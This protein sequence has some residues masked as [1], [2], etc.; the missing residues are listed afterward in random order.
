MRRLWLS[1]RMRS[2][3]PESRRYPERRVPCMC[4]RCGAFELYVRHAANLV[5]SPSPFHPMVS[6]LLC[7]ADVRPIHGAA[8]PDTTQMAHPHGGVSLAFVLQ[9]T[10]EGHMADRRNP[11]A[12]DSID[13]DDATRMSD[14]E[15]VG[16]SDDDDEE[17]E[18]VEDEGE[19]IEE[20]E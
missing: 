11:N 17:L 18:G 10:R 6:A 2:S 8:E 19:G 4:P 7:E 20:G 5:R 15:I 12:E 1:H 9:G 3:S 14:E 13:N 16:R